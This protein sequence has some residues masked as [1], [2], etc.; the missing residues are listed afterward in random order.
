MNEEDKS[1][2]KVT[3]NVYYYEDIT[4]L[5]DNLMSKILVA[6]ILKYSCAWP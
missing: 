1:M 2:V 3:L 5:K 6:A 4:I